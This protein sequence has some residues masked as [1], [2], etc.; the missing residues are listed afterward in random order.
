MKQVLRVAVV[1]GDAA[2][3]S[4]AS[5]AKRTAPEAE[6]TV[7]EQGEIVSYAA[8]GLPYLI[9]GIVPD[10]HDLIARTPEEFARQGITVRLRTE[11]IEIEPRLHRILVQNP[12]GQTERIAY[13]KLILA[14][15]AGPAPL[16]IPGTQL[17]GVFALR[18]IPDAQSIQNHI[19]QRK[20]RNAV[21]VGG[22]Y[23]GLEMAETFHHLRMNV[24]VIQR[25]SRLMSRTF[26]PE[27]SQLIR[28]HLESRGV[29]VLT[30]TEV[31]LFEG[32]DQ[33]KTVI[34]A[35]GQALPT[36]IAI[37]GV[38]ARPNVELAKNA[39][40]EIGPTGAIK[41]D[42]ALRTSATDVYAAGDCTETRHLVS[43]QLVYIPLGTTANK[44]GRF[45]GENAAG[46]H[47]IFRGVVGTAVCKIIE[48][49]AART[50]LTEDEALRLGFAAESS[51]IEAAAW[52]H[53]YGD[54]PN[55]HVR[56]TY[57][58]RTRKLLGAQLIGSEQAAK[59]VDVVAAALHASMTVDEF[60]EIDMSYAPP[61]APVWDPL[62]IAA[63]V[64]RG[65]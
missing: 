54:P 50:G 64:A 12:D 55:I 2:G 16:S 1:G 61:Y 45:A 25:S 8:C 15:G 32:T 52:A 6:I 42:N 60:A 27:M 20:P 13:D 47:A 34:T 40:I 31:R 30:D 36:E 38:G 63:N 56:L 62:L 65:K 28:E 48:L 41:V 26:D 57:D 19:S 29:T 5:K 59:R 3:M 58:A 37:V 23:I 39:G 9:S 4:A 10:V 49:T 18:T 51:Q 44:Q 33:L 17:P 11:V 14:T 21:I 53:Y 24:T 35:D 43:N 22:G 46:G 7:F